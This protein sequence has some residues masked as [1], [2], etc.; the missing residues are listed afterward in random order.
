MWV[1]PRLTVLRL[2]I[3]PI[4]GWINIPFYQISIFFS[5]R[6]GFTQQAALLM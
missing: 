2:G 6:N 1:E 3:L 4:A 5:R